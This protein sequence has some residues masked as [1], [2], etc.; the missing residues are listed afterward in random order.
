MARLIS[1]HDGRKYELCPKL[2][3]QDRRDV[4]QIL[5]GSAAKAPGRRSCALTLRL[6]TRLDSI[7]ADVVS[8][9]E[10]RT[11]RQHSQWTQD[12]QT[13]GRRLRVKHNRSAKQQCAKATGRLWAP[14]E[15]STEGC[16]RSQHRDERGRMIKF[17]DVVSRTSVMRTSDKSAAI[18]WQPR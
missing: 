11:R 12:E 17:V 10:T 14:H 1:S 8:C 4:G 9:A 13:T 5:F 3:R 15:E 16:R 2:P 18:F 7:R 6:L